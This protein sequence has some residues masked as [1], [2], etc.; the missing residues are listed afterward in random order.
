MIYK[1]VVVGEFLK[2]SLFSLISC[3]L[4]IQIVGEI[5]KDSLFSLDSCNC[6][7]RYTFGINCEL[8]VVFAFQAVAKYRDQQNRQV[9]QLEACFLAGN[10]L[11]SCPDS[12]LRKKLTLVPSAHLVD[13][14]AFRKRLY[15]FVL[16][17]SWNFIRQNDWP[18][19]SQTKKT[20]SL[21]PK[22]NPR[23]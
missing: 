11:N 6:T 14:S 1:Y 7:F 17:T 12:D 8:Y 15:D 18:I 4:Y 5:L 22:K 3:K 2:E 16:W 13:K 9:S 23:S 10:H 19:L 20:V 21:Y